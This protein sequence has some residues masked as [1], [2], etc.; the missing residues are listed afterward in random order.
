M[1]GRVVAKSQA[2]SPPPSETRSSESE[3]EK[4]R[5]SRKEKPKKPLLARVQKVVKKSRRK[6]SEDHFEKE[7]QR[8]ITFL[9][10]IQAKLGE[11][12]SSD[13]KRPRVAKKQK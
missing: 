6:L 5:P 4:K 11:P 7:L 13:K 9:E 10:G 8:T 12:P 3:K 1:K 2:S